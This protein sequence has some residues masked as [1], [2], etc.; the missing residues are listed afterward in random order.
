MGLRTKSDN[1]HEGGLLRVM[2][3]SASQGVKGRPMEKV[4]EYLREAG[5]CRDLAAAALLPKVKTFLLQ[6]ADRLGRT[7][8]QARRTESPWFRR[9][10]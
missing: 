8:P 9:F 3:E 2:R 10:P 4:E 5:E 1:F 6:M 7:R